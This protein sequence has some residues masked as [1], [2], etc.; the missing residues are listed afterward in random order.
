LNKFAS[1]GKYAGADWSFGNVPK[2]LMA[3]WSVRV[4]VVSFATLSIVLGWHASSGVDRT[5][6]SPGVLKQRDFDWRQGELMFLKAALDR[7]DTDANRTAPD[8]PAFRSLHTEQKAVILRMREV[9][10]P[11]PAESLPREL[12]L[13]AKDEQLAA[14]ETTL[15]AALDIATG[16]AAG[17]AELQVGLT[18]ASPAPD[19]ALSRD[20]A[21]NLVILTVPP[22]PAIG[23]TADNSAKLQP[24][25]QDDTLAKALATTWFLQNPET[26]VRSDVLSTGH[27]GFTSPART[28]EPRAVAEI[29]ATG[30]VPKRFESITESVAPR[31]RELVNNTEPPRPS[32]PKKE[33]PFTGPSARGFWHRAAQWE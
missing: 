19:I 33:V 18:S 5:L 24:A 17:L 25:N 12:R 1:Q 7:L 29:A 13:L 11:L 30:D 10:R 28:K 22:R 21:L 6:G 3:R 4:A 8:S 9:A 14:V 27:G 20:P 15:L 26:R 2:Q 23:S 31:G 16:G 32:S